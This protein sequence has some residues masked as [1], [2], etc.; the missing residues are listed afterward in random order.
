MK[1]QGPDSPHQVVSCPHQAGNEAPLLQRDTAAHLR[2]MSNR[3]HLAKDGLLAAVEAAPVIGPAPLV[4]QPQACL[5]VRHSPVQGQLIAQCPQ[6]T[7]VVHP[8]RLR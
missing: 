6:S 7:E 5:L 2:Q 3:T 1:Q 4:L 8:Q